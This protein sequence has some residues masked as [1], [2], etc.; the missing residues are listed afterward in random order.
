MVDWQQMKSRLHG[1][2]TVLV[3]IFFSS[4]SFFSPD[5]LPSQ[6]IVDNSVSYMQSLDGFSFKL[7]RSGAPVYV[8]PTGIVTF[9]QAE[10][11][12]VS[13]DKVAGTVKVIA[14]AIV[15]EVD[16]IGIG[17]KEWE[18]NIFTG[19]WFVVPL[20]YAFKPAV[21]FD[22]SSGMQPA[23]AEHLENITLIDVS[24]I[25]ELPGLQLYH[26][27]ATMDGIYVSELTYT[28]IDPQPL[29]IELWIEPGIFALHRMTIVDPSDEEATEPT[30]W[31]LDFWDFDKVIEIRPP[32]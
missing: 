32:I 1:L 19:E 30:Y 7:E 9:R 23:L 29:D 11:S 3:V 25:E 15:A 27:S 16:I 2:G 28:L 13:P 5:D 21:L 6:T 31:Q 17:E 12:F 20:E 24:E 26:I 4:C 10:G 14:P 18:T 22:P 8:D